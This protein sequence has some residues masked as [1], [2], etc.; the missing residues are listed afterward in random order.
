MKFFRDLLD[1]IADHK[2]RSAVVAGGAIVG[3]ITVSATQ[4]ASEPEPPPVGGIPQ[5]GDFPTLASVGP[6]PDP[7]IEYTGDCDFTSADNNLVIEDRI[8]DCEA[9]GL[10][11]FNGAENIT[12]RNSIIKGPM[13]TQDD[14]PDEV[15]SDD[16][17]R[18]YIFIVENSDILQLNTT[19]G[20]DRSVCCS[21]YRVEN[22]YLV[23]THSGMGAHNNVV[24][25]GNYIT[26][27]GSDNHTSGMRVLKNTLIED[28]TISC[29]PI[30]AGSDGGCSAAGV[31][32]SEKIN[33]DPAAS[34]NLTI[35]HN[36]FKRGV[37]AA[38]EPGGPWF[39]TRFID[40]AN[41]TDCVDNHFTNNLFDLGW[42]TDAGE[43]PVSY[44]GNTWSHNYW[45]DEEVANSGQ[46][47]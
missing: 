21:H 33:G 14:T 5:V 1:S 42:G 34:F 26:T 27:T 10:R 47:R 43:F 13:Y 44:G 22:S 2:K 8:V 35:N 16:F 38:L 40:C 41:R 12:F 30:T 4:I 39:A 28:N 46:V 36:Y 9:T 45:V 11:F 24:A 7:T 3:L 20:L 31:Y 6:S 32:Y 37:T 25:I 18:N 19:A 23:G 15:S 29:T 17:P